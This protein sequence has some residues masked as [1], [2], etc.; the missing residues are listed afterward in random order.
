MKNYYD[1]GSKA[2]RMFK[3]QGSSKI[4]DFSKIKDLQK[5]RMIEDQG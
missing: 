2:W 5:S 3:D 1:Q 4:K